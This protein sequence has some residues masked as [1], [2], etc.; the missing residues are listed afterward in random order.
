MSNLSYQET[1]TQSVQ[2]L[3]QRK[4][5]RTGKS[6][7]DLQSSEA[8]TEKTLLLGRSKPFPLLQRNQ[9]KEAHAAEDIPQDN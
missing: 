5:L 6:K 9:H 8:V 4:K 3:A 7:K 2:C 1:V